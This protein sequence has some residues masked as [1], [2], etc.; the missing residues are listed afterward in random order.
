M[1]ELEGGGG[2]DEGVVERRRRLCEDDEGAAKLPL[3]P[4]IFF[5]VSFL[6]NAKFSIN[7]TTSKEET[8]KLCV[9]ENHRPKSCAKVGRNHWRNHL[10]PLKHNAASSFN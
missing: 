8:S 7:R 4:S 2:E 1:K 9:L 5:S 10:A 6:S 3:F